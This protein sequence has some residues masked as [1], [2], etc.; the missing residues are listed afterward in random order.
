MMFETS[1]PSHKIAA[2]LA[3]FYKAKPRALS[4]NVTSNTLFEVNSVS[5]RCL[6][7]R[8]HERQKARAATFLAKHLT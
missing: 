1:T 3:E 8:K 2:Y 5:L 7:V 4:G 6:T